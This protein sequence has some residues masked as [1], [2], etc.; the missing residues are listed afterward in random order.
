VFAAPLPTLTMA[1]MEHTLHALATLWFV[2]ISAS[3]LAQRRPIGAKN[4]TLVALL[5]A[6]T[7]SLRYEGFFAV[8]CVVLLFG[9]TRRLR[10]A[11]AVGVA[12]ALPA[13]GYGLWAVQHGWF[14]LPNSVL[15]KG[16]TPARGLNAVIAFAAGSPALH[17]LLANPHILIM[18]VA[19]LTL[20]VVVSSEVV[21]GED[22]YLLTILAGASLL[23]MQ[24]A[25]SGW[26]Y[27][28]EAYLLVLGAAV[29]GAVAARRLPSIHEWTR[30]AA[31]WPRSLALAV[32]VAVAGFPFASRGLNAFRNTPTAA[33]NIYFQQYQMGLFA[34][35]YYAGQSVAVNDIGAV[36]FL[37]DAELLDVYGLASVDVATLKRSGRQWSQDLG[38]LAARQHA[39]VAMIYPSWLNESGG[40]PAGWTK[41]G[42]WGVHDNVV[43]G[44]N[45]VSFYSV[46]ADERPTL[47]DNLR[48]FAPVLPAGVVQ[49]GEYRQ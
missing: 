21:W 31:M 39:R 6:L 46:S 7:T 41:V 37:G 27:R 9:F 5:G 22:V 43:L 8:A 19:A 14:F 34:A 13:I 36:G 18:V 29:F 33:E 10:E 24:L 45:A 30:S 35:R 17:N 11:A 42:E 49:A 15:L 32:L 1:G 4:L 38:A 3:L 23:H 16:Q 44:E 2:F 12:A 25:R 26:F 47:L 40:V 28:Y 48:R 20:L